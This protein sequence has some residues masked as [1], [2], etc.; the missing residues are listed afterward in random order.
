MAQELQLLGYH[1][2][3]VGKWHMGF[4]EWSYTPLFRGFDS[5]YGYYGGSI[6]Y[7][8][9]MNQ[10]AFLDLFDNMSPVVDSTELTGHLT[11]VL[12]TRVETLI[13]SHAGSESPLFLFYAMQNSN[14][15][16]SWFLQLI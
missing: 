1:T 9:K 13:Q 16:L 2:A 12:Q 11:E 6:G 15:I 5:F 3:L 10:A 7:Y 4:E 8:S 14:D